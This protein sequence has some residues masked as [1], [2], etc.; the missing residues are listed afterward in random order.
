MS[1][2]NLFPREMEPGDDWDGRVFDHV[3]PMIDP[4]PERRLNCV[5]VFQDGT[6][7][8]WHT[9]AP[10]RIYRAAH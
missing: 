5:M 6:T 9:D 10:M 4:Q 8:L 1:F 3:E 7:R 2:L